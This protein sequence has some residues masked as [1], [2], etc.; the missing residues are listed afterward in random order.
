[1]QPGQ[2]AP[3]NPAGVLGRIFGFANQPPIV[4]G[5][6]PQ[7]QFPQ[8][9]AANINN[10]N[11]AQIPVN[12][13]F[14]AGQL[15]Q[16][17]VVQYHIQL[18]V[19]R[20]QQQPPTQ[21]QP[22]PTPGFAGFQGPGGVWQPWGM[23]R[24]W[25]LPEQAVQVP[26]PNP[27]PTAM[28][29]STPDIPP[30][31]TTPEPTP[32][33]TGS[34]QPRQPSTTPSTPSTSGDSSPD[35]P[36]DPRLAAALAAYRRRSTNDRN[37]R[38]PGTDSES[39][40]ASASVPEEHSTAVSTE[41]VEESSS[42]ASAP[43]PS[44]PVPTNRMGNGLDS[45]PRI[46]SLIPLYDYRLAPSIRTQ[47]QPPQQSANPHLQP[48]SM[49]T[50]QEPQLRPPT[51]QIP[52]AEP[53]QYHAPP[54]PQLPPTLTDEQLAVMDNLTREAIDERLRVLEGVSGAVFRCIDDLMR[55]R[56]VLPS[57]STPTTA[58]VPTPPNPT[59]F[60]GDWPT[61]ASASMAETGYV[62]DDSVEAEETSLSKPKDI[63]GLTKENPKPT[64][65]HQPGD[66]PT[67]SLDGD[68]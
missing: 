55:M 36:N 2:Q 9:P 57:S 26:D 43:V 3:N 15:P 60:P 22:P 37:A 27:A 18:Q 39:R 66:Q 41:I 14:N 48:P 52:V 4:P 51:T 67:R 64:E 47:P 35:V 46:P 34:D 23:D 6:F 13:A 31:Q 21:A 63:D 38:I 56:S 62:S 42:A 32:T 11:N 29:T 40:T 20:H 68:S 58:A 19:P 5:Q 45:K 8:F 44:R 53:R 25:F 10:V 16:G 61:P 65:V 33:Q 1:M 7:G 30:T 28:R 50:R 49:Q 17:I 54:A 12:A 24:R 59:T